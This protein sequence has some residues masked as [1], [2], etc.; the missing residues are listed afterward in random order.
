MR[1]VY[2]RILFLYVYVFCTVLMSLL[3]LLNQ[4]CSSDKILETWLSLN[5]SFYKFYLILVFILFLNIYV[6]H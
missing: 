3:Y 1:D 6:T 2:Y 5:F 4:A